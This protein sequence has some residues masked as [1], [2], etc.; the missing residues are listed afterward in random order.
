[1]MKNESPINEDYLLNNYKIENELKEVFDLSKKLDEQYNLFISEIEVNEF[2][3]NENINIKATVNPRQNNKRTKKRFL[4][5]QFE[6]I[7]MLWNKFTAVTPLMYAV[8]KKIILIG[9]ILAV[10]G[11]LVELYK[12]IGDLFSYTPALISVIDVPIRDEEALDSIVLRLNEENVKVNVTPDGVIYV[13]D[14][15][16]AQRMRTILL[17]ENLIPDG[18]EP[19]AV[20]NTERW[21]ITEREHNINLQIALTQ[22]ISDHIKTIEG[23][24]DLN[25]FINWPKRELFYVDQKPVT[26]SVIIIPKIGSDITKNSKKIEGIQKILKFAVEGLDDE[27]IIIS[28]QNGSILNNFK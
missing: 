10:I 1:M 2:L 18:I 5:K 20:F 28:D 27:N 13:A 21:S 4:R 16:T 26:A 9:I 14:E 3:Q 15:A 23:I 8:I 17:S 7:S 12:I 25:L 19:W 6:N 22:M 24:S 11:F